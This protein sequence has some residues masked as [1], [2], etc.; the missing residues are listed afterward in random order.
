[1]CSSIKNDFLDKSKRNRMAELTALKPLKRSIP[2]GL[3]KQVEDIQK[4]DQ[5]TIGI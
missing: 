5:R 3:Q 2:P 4:K 1:M